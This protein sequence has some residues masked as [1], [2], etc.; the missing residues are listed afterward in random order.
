[1]LRQKEIRLEAAGVEA[2]MD[3]ADCVFLEKLIRHSCVERES[4]W[5][6]RKQNC[7]RQR[8][9]SGPKGTDCS[10]RRYTQGCSEPAFVGTDVWAIT[11]QW[12]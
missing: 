5:G 10:T 7:G 11:A 2:G 9:S 1:V 6:L 12:S 3:K 8:S 4:L